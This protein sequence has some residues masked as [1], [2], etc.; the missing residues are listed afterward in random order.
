MSTSEFE[1]VMNLI[2]EKMS[3][4]EIALRVAIS[5]Q[6]RLTWQKH[7]FSKRKQLGCNSTACTGL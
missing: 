2:E 6:E 1:F 5:I 4:K 7:I 3:K